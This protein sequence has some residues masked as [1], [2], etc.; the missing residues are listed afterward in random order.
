MRNI[1]IILKEIY[2]DREVFATGIINNLTKWKYY[3]EVVAKKKVGIIKG[4]PSYIITVSE[5]YR[6]EWLDSLAEL[7][8]DANKAAVKKLFMSE[9]AHD[10]VE[11]PV[12][13]IVDNEL[14]NYVLKFACESDGVIYSNVNMII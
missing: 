8:I 9:G 5:N 7:A 4:A 11:I 13:I 1:K 6:E 10:D 12:E 2:G 14:Y 3:N